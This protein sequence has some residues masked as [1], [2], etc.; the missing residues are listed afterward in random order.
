MLVV[1]VEEVKQVILQVRLEVL[2]VVDDIIIKPEVLEL[3]VKVTLEVL[4]LQAAH[5]LVVEVE[6][7]V[8]QVTQM[9]MDTEGMV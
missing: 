9:E 5:I 3:Q 6:E 4:V 2:E 1:E 7:P 8:R